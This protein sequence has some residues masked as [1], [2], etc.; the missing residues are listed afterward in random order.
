MMMMMVKVAEATVDV[1]SAWR[2]ARVYSAE[3]LAE[4]LCVGYICLV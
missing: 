1:A 2:S 3:A 4:W